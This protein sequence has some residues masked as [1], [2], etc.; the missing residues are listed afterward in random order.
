MNLWQGV[1]IVGVVLVIVVAIRFSVRSKAEANAAKVLQ[2][3]EKIVS[4][5]RGNAEMRSTM[6]IK[7]LIFN[8]NVTINYVYTLL[9][10]LK[11]EGKVKN[12]IVHGKAQENT[13]WFSL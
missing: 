1:L 9:Q 2:E 8:P 13:K 11:N 6:Q 10:D 7:E 3:K 12:T 5:L 4:F